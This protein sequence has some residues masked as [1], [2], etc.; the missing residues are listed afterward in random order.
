MH[1]CITVVA[2][3][4]RASLRLIL[5]RILLARTCTGDDGFINCIFKT[6]WFAVPLRAAFSIHH[7]L[8]TPARPANTCSIGSLEGYLTW[9][10]GLPLQEAPE[11]WHPAV[12]CALRPPS[13]S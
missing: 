5:H 12:C 9:I 3:S 2:M 11:V 4:G 13:Q 8:T 10:Q 7:T 1:H 6:E